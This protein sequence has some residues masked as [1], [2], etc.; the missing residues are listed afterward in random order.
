M[1]IDNALE[2]YIFE[3]SI[4]QQ[5]A[6]ATISS[7]E[8]QLKKYFEYL[9]SLEIRNMNDIDSDIIIDYIDEISD[10]LA[11]S[12]ITH[13]L[14]SIRN[15]HTFISSVDA[16]IINPSLKVKVRK[17][18]F[19][20][21]QV[22]SE[23]NLEL[24]FN[25][26][27]ESPKDI[28]NNALFEFLYSCGLRVSE[29]CNLDFN[30]LNKEN[31]ILRIKGKGSKIRYVPI[32][33]IA[34]T[35]LEAYLLLRQSYKNKQSNTIFI[36]EKGKT[37]SRQYVYTELQKIRLE[38]NI[39]QKISPHSFRHT[40]ATHLLDGGAD[41]RYVQE[42]LGHSDIATTQIYI[43]LQNKQLKSAYDQ[44]FKRGQ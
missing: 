43:H 7:Y 8:N 27:T 13:A 10:D 38:E 21:P 26:F 32:S 17:N 3:I 1:T 33:E 41:L 12:T 44:F 36:N 42:L 15:F 18:K 11:S 29:L 22:I 25:S 4:N 39:S 16:T 20:L 24:I 9:N 40:Y 37:I 2:M 35:K 34:V 30:D 5:L 28:L 23:K 14:S 19:V 31:K 6:A